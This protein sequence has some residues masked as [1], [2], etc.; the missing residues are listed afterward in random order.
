MKYWLLIS[1]PI[2]FLALFSIGCNGSQKA[3]SSEEQVMKDKIIVLI[4]DGYN[5]MKLEAVFEEYG[6]K[7]HGQMSRTENRFVMIYDMN[8]ITPE[9][10]LEKFRGAKI[11]LEA[12]FAPLT[13]LNN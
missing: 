4:K 13:R 5:S 7:T 6:V 1:I 2:L 11:V 8:K 3:T 9:E 12:E 10:M